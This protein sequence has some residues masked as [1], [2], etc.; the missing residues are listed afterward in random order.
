[1]SEEIVPITKKFFA[2]NWKENQ[3]P[4]LLEKNA[5]VKYRCKGNLKLIRRSEIIDDEFIK[6]ERFIMGVEVAKNVL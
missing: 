2:G 3:I 5:I 6:Y 1:M 4:L